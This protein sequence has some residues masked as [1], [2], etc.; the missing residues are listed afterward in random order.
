L[1]V[2]LIKQARDDRDDRLTPA[3]KF[4]LMTVAS[5]HSE[6]HPESG[7]GI[8]NKRLAEDMGVDVRT[9]QRNL[10]A[11]VSVGKITIEASSHPR[12]R[13]RIY[14]S[15]ATPTSL[16]KDI[17][18]TPTSL[19]KDIQAT[20]ASLSSD[21][22]VAPSDTS[23]ASMRQGSNQGRTI[24]AESKTSAPSGHGGRTD[25]PVI[26]A[27]DDDAEM[28]EAGAPPARRKKPF[29]EAPTEGTHAWVVYR[30]E[31]AMRREQCGRHGFNKGV[32]NATLKAL[33]EE[34]FKNAEIDQMVSVFWA[35]QGSV[36]R[37]KKE[38]DVAVAFRHHLP[39]LKEATE[40]EIRLKRSGK[41]T[42]A[43][44]GSALGSELKDR[45]MRLAEENRSASA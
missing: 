23:V 36:I 34:G 13:G 8:T 4:T 16:A 29:A 35:R 31:Q 41:K 10:T 14:M 1:S 9:V 30:F 5:H 15:Q 2:T 32:L 27:L 44:I 26:G 38:L 28:P 39:Q 43:E 37:G 24:K 7:T 22:S 40:A 11:L 42:S 33:R 12:R 3:L 17:Q 20:P 45:L 21:T 6:K 19:A 18:A 25:M